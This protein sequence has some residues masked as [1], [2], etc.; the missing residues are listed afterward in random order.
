MEIDLSEPWKIGTIPT[1]QY[2]STP[3]LR[4][5]NENYWE[6]VFFVD[7]LLFLIHIVS[8]KAEEKLRFN[9]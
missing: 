3:T 1:L 7:K 4:G 6:F 9:K 2:S 8:I 5:Q